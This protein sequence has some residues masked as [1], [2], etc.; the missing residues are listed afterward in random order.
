LGEQE[1]EGGEF[2][3]AAGQGI[4]PGIPVNPMR[5]SARWGPTLVNPVARSRWRASRRASERLT[6]SRRQPGWRV[7]W[8]D[9]H[10]PA[11]ACRLRVRGVAAIG[12]G[13]FRGCG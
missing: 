3:L 5:Q 6:S 7:S 11:P 8:F 1:R 13:R 9:A 12:R 2:R 10:A 4:T